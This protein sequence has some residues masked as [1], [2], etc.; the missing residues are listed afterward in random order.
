MF[1]EI[2]LTLIITLVI[3]GLFYII[4][5]QLKI[6]HQNITE[7]KVTEGSDSVVTP[8]PIVSGE[9][10]DT[11]ESFENKPKQR[12]NIDK[13]I[14]I[15]RY[16]KKW[17]SVKHENDDPSKVRE[18]MLDKLMKHP[19]LDECIGNIK[20]HK[21]ELREVCSD[22]QAKLKKFEY[23]KSP[24]AKSTK[25]D[26]VVMLVGA[27]GSG[28][29][30]LI[31]SMVN[32]VFGVEFEDNFRFKLIT[33]DDE[34]N[35]NQAHSQTSWITAY[36]IHHQKGFK[37]DFTLTIVDTPGFGDTRGVDR[38]NEIT[39]QIRKFFIASG[40][41]GIDH[42][43]VVGFVAQS[44]L[45]RLTHTQR[46][47]F[48]QILALFGKDVGQNIYLMLTFGDGQVPQVL[49]GFQEAR[50]PYQEYYKFNNSVIFDDNHSADDFC[51]MFWNMG[52]CSFEKF[53]GQFPKITS[54]SLKLTKQVLEER[55]RI[56][57]Q[58]EGLQNEVKSG[59]SKLEQLRR[60]VQVVL[61]HEN[62]IVRNKDF[63][64]TV[65]E[66]TI[67]KHDLKPGTYVTNCITCNVTCH[68]PCSI[69][70][71]DNKYKCAAMDGGGEEH[72]K[73]IVCPKGCSWQLHK[74]MQYYFATQSN[75]VTK[76]SDE[77]KQRYQDANGRIHSSQQIVNGLINE[78]EA[79]QIKIVGITDVL[80]KSINKLNKIALKPSSLS[81]SEYIT[82]LI[83]AERTTAEPGWQDRVENLTDVKNRV[84]SLVQIAAEGFDPFEAFKRRIQEEK[85]SKQGVWHAVGTYLEK[86][87]FW[88]C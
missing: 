78:F 11:C 44:S 56:E 20:V 26:K 71:D 3:G 6:S 8:N 35:Q 54:K 34:I 50:L 66:D 74:N 23:G 59:L 43:D 15:I 62:D 5:I 83:Q 24:L 2:L 45:P 87:Q 81:T 18:K 37:V 60:E 7:F 28:K 39:K 67:V 19:F 46:Y 17:P 72:A 41:Q 40:K 61:D 86:I 33:E 42:L 52:M 77:L 38:D 84:E 12:F 58:V 25:K 14:P 65:N 76:T 68:Y 70:D 51:K 73:C 63:T 9:D 53:F 1:L 13:V 57:T 82:I 29:T 16:M 27:T 85:Q 30:T 21:L 47:I 75:S 36:T 48:D 80:R 88:S 55:D 64:Y 4:Q 69:P 22:E 32:Y 10:L 49:T 79:V 31:N